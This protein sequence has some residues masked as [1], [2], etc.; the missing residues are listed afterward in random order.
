MLSIV[1]EDLQL[2]VNYKN[3]FILFELKIVPNTEVSLWIP[4][5]NIKE[6]LPYKINCTTINNTINKIVKCRRK[7]W[8]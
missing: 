7:F 6:K 8:S 5:L 2:K 4:N 1:V 3:E